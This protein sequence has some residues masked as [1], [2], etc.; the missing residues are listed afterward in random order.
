V[1]DDLDNLRFVYEVRL[2]ARLERERALAP[3]LSA[4]TAGRLL[5]ARQRRLLGSATRLT[6]DLLPE[7]YA[8]AQDCLTLLGGALVGDLYVHQSSEYNA[9]AFAAGR[10]FDI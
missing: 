9:S 7:L 3:A 1:R 2:F 4:R 8:T 10:H 5:R 6:P